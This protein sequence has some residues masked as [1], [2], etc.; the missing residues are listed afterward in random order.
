MDKSQT[1][2]DIKS[3]LYNYNQPQPDNGFFVVHIIALKLYM[4]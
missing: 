2:S 4:V 3:I 1:F